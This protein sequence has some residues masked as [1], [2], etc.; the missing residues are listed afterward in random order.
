MKFQQPG[1]L[2]KSPGPITTDIVN[3]VFDLIT[4][5]ASQ[6]ESFQEV[7]EDFKSRFAYGKNTTWSSSSSWA[8]TDLRMYMEE[9]TEN[10]P[11]FIAAFVDGC[12][13]ITKSGGA[14]PDVD[15]INDLLTKH[16]IG[17]RIQNDTVVVADNVPAVGSNAQSGSASSAQTAATQ[18]KKLR[19]FLCP[20][21]GD[22]PAVRDIYKR[23]RDDGFSPWLDEENLI[24]GQ[25]WD[26]VIKKTVRESHVVVVCLSNNSINKAGY[27]QKEIV[28]ALDV[29]DEQPEGTIFIIPAR[30]EDC[31][32]PT[33]LS[34]WH[35]VDLFKSN[36][37]SKLVEALKLRAGGL[38]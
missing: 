31:K 7:L 24:P 12:I 5:M 34:K 22:K 32:V 20:S 18:A 8:Q 17:Y 27:A 4:T 21:S 25:D 26:P 3:D 13:D 38:K 6:A 30:L 37:Y 11:K 29:A 10:A 36:G 2:F 23:L 1:W 14:A 9:A 35:Y 28:V 15:F 19:V 16:K 33:R